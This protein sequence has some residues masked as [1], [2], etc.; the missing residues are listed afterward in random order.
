MPRDDQDLTTRA[1]AGDRAA[2]DRL[3]AAALP[4]VMGVLRRLVGHP[5]DCEDI[6]QE[7]LADA[8]A[9]IAGFRAEASFATWLTAIAARRA[10]DHL[11]RA[12]R[13]RREAQVAYANLCAADETLA[14]E[15]MAVAADPGFAFDLKAHVAYCFSCVGRSLPPDEMAALV[16]RDVAG[17]STREAA[18]ALGVSDSVLRHRLA[19]A[20]AAM[21]E[22]YEG[23]CA[24]VSKQGICHQC[25]GLR[26]LDPK[27]PPT[28][29]PEIDSLAQR[30]A[31]VREAAPGSGMAALHD[32]F[33]RRTAE[34][35]AEGRG[36]AKPQ[37]DCGQPDAG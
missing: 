15:V 18:T 1:R 2:F 24:L 7:A 10:A 23:L 5:Q 22:R 27:A 35:E 8:W 32:L 16:L 34:I 3:A 21:T 26:M 17:L 11:R 28:P 9:G 25:A 36:S 4:R 6:A 37:S 19:A 14:G 29:L 20:R 33:W 13:W 30:I 31:M 12:R